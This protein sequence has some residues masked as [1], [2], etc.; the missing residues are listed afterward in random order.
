MKVKNTF[1]LPGVYMPQ[2]G[3]LKHALSYDMAQSILYECEEGKWFV[4]AAPTHT[5]PGLEE[6]TKELADNLLQLKL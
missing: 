2:Y 6:I 4:T 5:G 3:H 1:I